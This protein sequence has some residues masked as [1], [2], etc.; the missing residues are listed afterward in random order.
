MLKLNDSKKIQII[1]KIIL[2]CE[3]NVFAIPRNYIERNRIV[4]N[5]GLSFTVHNYKQ[6][7]D[8]LTGDIFKGFKLGNGFSGDYVRK[9]IDMLISDTLKTGIE[10]VKKNPLIIDSFDDEFQEVFVYIPLDGIKIEVDELK[11]GKLTLR[12]MNEL[13]VD[14]IYNQFLYL[15]ANNQLVSKKMFEFNS[16]II[17]N[18]ILNF[19]DKTIAEFMIFAEE[20]LA[21]EE[22]KKECE[23]VID[24]LRFSCQFFHTKEKTSIGLESEIQRGNYQ[25]I[26]HKADFYGYEIPNE[27]IGPVFEFEI[28]DS[29]LD[30][31]EETGIIKLSKIF[32]KSSR[33]RTD[34]EKMI[35]SGLHWFSDSM[36][37]KQV[38][39][40]F[41]SLMICLEI[42]LTP[43]GERISGFISE[44][45][46]KIIC[47]EL[48]D[49]IELKKVIKEM[50]EK[51]SKIVHGS[52]KKLPNIGDVY[53]LQHIVAN[54]LVWMVNR[55][56]YFTKKK[57]LIDFIEL[58]KLT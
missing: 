13:E 41:L 7:Y 56:D 9:F 36:T 31:M 23:G 30:F 10:L 2:I 16:N 44:A 45:A 47:D 33:E 55:S 11:I 17:K 8:E 18:V 3:N 14:Y 4:K 46:A 43:G 48:I 52:G 42:F 24:L 34:F 40:Q 39:N 21:V 28:N 12:K 35:I 54:L 51:R 57:D 38:E 32:G 29:T 19:K 49:R 27:Y 37:Q 5:K 1:N 53:Q 6:F 25:I 20:K 22:A 58:H 15:W 50:Y 26:V